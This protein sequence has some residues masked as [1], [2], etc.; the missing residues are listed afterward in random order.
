ME[1]FTPCQTPKTSAEPLWAVQ[2]G[3]I[4]GELTL[5]H[6]AAPRTQA[7]YDQKSAESFN[8]VFFAQLELSSFCRLALKSIKNNLKLE[9]LTLV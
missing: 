6:K 8:S 3:Q 5:Q 9:R 1:L 4:L 2:M 7:H